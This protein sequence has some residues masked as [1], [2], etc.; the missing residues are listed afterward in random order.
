MPIGQFAL[1]F[2]TEILFPVGPELYQVDKTN[3]Y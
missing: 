2:L 3:Y 1:N